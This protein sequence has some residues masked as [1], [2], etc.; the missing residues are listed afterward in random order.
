MKPQK[1][2]SDNFQRIE[3]QVIGIRLFQIFKLVNPGLT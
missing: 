3:K 2:Q 1:F